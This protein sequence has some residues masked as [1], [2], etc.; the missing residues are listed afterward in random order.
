MIRQSLLE[1]CSQLATLT[2]KRKQRCAGVG[3]QLNSSVAAEALG[4]V[5]G[6]RAI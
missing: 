2:L 3:S 1:G 5:V 6:Q 4:C